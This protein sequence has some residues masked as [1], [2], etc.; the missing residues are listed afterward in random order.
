MWSFRIREDFGS[1]RAQVAQ[2]KQHFDTFRRSVV[3]REDTSGSAFERTAVL[4]EIDRL[5]RPIGHQ[6]SNCSSGTHV[7]L[8]SANGF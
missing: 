5:D 1:E 3:L 8:L 2:L 4:M 7:R 6:H